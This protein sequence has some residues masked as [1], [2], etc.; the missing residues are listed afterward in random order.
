MTKE[1]QRSQALSVGVPSSP[2]PTALDF[3]GQNPLPHPPSEPV[4][5]LSSEDPEYDQLPWCETPDAA[6]D[7]GLI[8][9][10]WAQVAEWEPTWSAECGRAD[11]WP[12]AEE[13]TS[14]SRPTS[15]TPSATLYIDADNQSAQC[16]A[17]LISLFRDD[18]GVRNLSAVIAGNNC[19]SLIA[20]WAQEL[21]AAAPDI[22]TIGIE[23]PSRKDAADIA[24]IMELGAN[25]EGHIQ[26]GELVV[27]VSRDDLLVGAA[28]HA[29]THGCRALA[30]YVDSDPPCARSSRVTTL[31]LP[32]P[33]KQ[34]TAK[35]PVR[36]LISTLP[37]GARQAAASPVGALNKAAAP[38]S[39]NVNPSAKLDTD[40]NHTQVLAKLR[41]MCTPTPEGT[42]TASEVGQA[43]A[44]LGYGA[45]ARRHILTTTPGI[46]TQGKATAKVYRF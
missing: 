13:Q 44:K 2:Q 46:Q 14:Q 11:D 22:Q 28:E 7:P 31:L 32:T 16:A 27:I 35:P 39:A 17:D 4:T 29:K 25:L 24:L 41:S 6:P 3:D 21:Q 30:A 18:F 40:S 1:P 5:A 20:V 8:N 42:Y 36:R 34:R 12:T 15:A 38:S 19:G 43:L 9:T 10:A 45:K 37:S 33:G 23:V 26:C